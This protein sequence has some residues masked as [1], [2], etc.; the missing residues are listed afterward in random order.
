MIT[1]LSI[2]LGMGIALSVAGAVRGENKPHKETAPT[3][4]Q[5][6]SQG[7]S[8]MRAYVDPETG[9]LVSQPVTEAQRLEAAAAAEADNLNYSDIGLQKVMLPDGS[10]MVDLQG[11]Y[12]MSMTVEVQPDG[13][14]QASCTDSAHSAMGA[15]SHDLTTTA[16]PA[17]V[18][19]DVR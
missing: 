9:A 6:Q 5:A 16:T 13:S 11:R 18:A 2:T 12:Q 14:L 8:G 10:V 1:K 17:P 7:Q 3:A 15:H 19:R 4:A